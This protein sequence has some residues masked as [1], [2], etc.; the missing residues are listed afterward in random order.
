[1]KLIT[2]PSFG[3]K[4]LSVKQFLISQIL[5]LIIGLIIL[6]GIYYIL[7][8]QYPTGLNNPFSNG[9]VTTKPKSF[10]LTLDEPVDNTLVFAP[11]ILVSGKTS[12]AKEVLIFTDSKNMVIKSKSDGS[13][14]TDL[15]LDEGENLIT[16]VVFDDNGET[17]SIERTIYYSKEKI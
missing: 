7:N 17:K 16:V 4:K 14:S 10:L 15:D 1:M 8:V 6:S 5:L 12:S 13:F 11:S 2:H 3:G 9:P